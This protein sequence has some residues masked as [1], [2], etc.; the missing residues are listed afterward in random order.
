MSKEINFVFWA[1]GGDGSKTASHILAHAAFIEGK[2]VQAF[3]EY[4]P[5]RSG[6]PMRTYVKISDSK[7]SNSAPF[8]IAD[9]NVFIDGSLLLLPDLEK[10]INSQVSDNT[11]FLLN[12]KEKPELKNKLYFIDASNIAIKHL[13]KDLPNIVLLGV[14]VK[15]S[16]IVKLESLE[17][18]IEE[19][20]AN[21]KDLLKQNIDAMIEAYNSINP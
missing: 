1:R 21:K 11:I 8:K 2:E 15:I 10:M 18:A 13:N 3:P 7:I 19:V 17:K 20:F 6:A 14:L 9:Y 5:E 16:K 4:G 12:A